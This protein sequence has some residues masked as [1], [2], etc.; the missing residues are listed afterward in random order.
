VSDDAPAFVPKVVKKPVARPKPVVEVS[1]T[2]V[3]NKVSSGIY[4]ES[5]S[6]IERFVEA[7]REELQSAV[8]QDKRVRLR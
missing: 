2:R 1:A 7:L 6:D 3:F 8:K 5:D 4:L